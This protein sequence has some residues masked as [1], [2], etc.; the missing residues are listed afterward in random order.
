[1]KQRLNLTHIRIRFLFIIIFLVRS[2]LAI[3]PVDTTVIPPKHTPDKRAHYY[4]LAI[5][6]GIL[7]AG[8][9]FWNYSDRWTGEFSIENE[10]WFREDSYNGGADKLGHAYTWSILTRVLIYNYERHGFSRKASA[11][12]GVT[13]P[14]FNGVIVELLDGYTDYNASVEDILFNLLGSGLAAFLYLH[15]YLDETFHLD[16]S[17][18]PS[19]DYKNKIKGDFTTDYA[20]QMFTLEMN[21]KGMKKMIG[22][23][24]PNPL[25]FFQIGLSYYTRGYSGELN[26][27]KQRTAGVTIGVNL[28]ELFHQ[29]NLARPLVKYYKIPFSFLGWFRD[30]NSGSV[31]LKNGDEIFNY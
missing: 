16:W 8:A 31:G 18:L 24:K 14:L 28:Q 11:F 6:G 4:S 5:Q 17:Y 3:E 23:Q 15:P 9:I 29:N 30:L 7:I 21:L 25:D 27:L 1:M 22:V 26:T 12:W 2:L 19:S 13:I 10:G 20:G